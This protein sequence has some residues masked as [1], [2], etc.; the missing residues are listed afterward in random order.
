MK[1][2]D[3]IH[4]AIHLFPLENIPG[5]T[6]YRNVMYNWLTLHFSSFTLD[7]LVYPSRCETILSPDITVDHGQ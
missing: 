4:V 3:S 5:Y 1:L 2:L 7:R 6:H